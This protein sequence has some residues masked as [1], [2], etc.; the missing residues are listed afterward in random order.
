MKGYEKNMK[1]VVDI[2]VQNG[3]GVASFIALIYFM[4]T[5]LLDIKETNEEISKTL[6]LIQNNLTGLEGRISLIER[7][8]NDKEI[9][10]RES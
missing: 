8:I 7:N 10:N 5:S 9:N 6:T 3:L 1:E 2:I 4:K